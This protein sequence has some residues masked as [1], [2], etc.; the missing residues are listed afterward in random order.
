MEEKLARLGALIEKAEKVVVFSGAGIS[1]ES[2]IPDFRGPGGVWEKHDPNDY[3][4]DRFLNDPDARKRYWLRSTEM[5]Q[6]I[7]KTAP[8][9]GHLAVSAL[10]ESGKLLALITQNVDGLHQDAG[11]PEALIIELHGNTRSVSC[12]SCGNHVPRQGFQPLVS[13]EG[14]AP[15]CAHCGGLMKPAT[16][17]FGQM[18][19]PETLQRADSASRNCDLFIVVGS[20]LVVY[21]AAGFP[22]L[23]VESGA[24]LVIVNNQPTPHD[25]YA[26]LVLNAPSGEVLPGALRTLPTPLPS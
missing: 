9:P 23:A 13:A 14:V 16:I 19:V 6:A 18:L 22:L 5:Y 21:P 7:L 15:P 1:T 25:P 20:S 17:S 12:L 10:A 8:N 4:I 24:D 26:K 3:H 2:G 11:T